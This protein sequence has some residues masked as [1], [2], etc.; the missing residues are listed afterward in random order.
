MINRQKKQESNILIQIWNQKIVL[1]VLIFLV[2]LAFFDKYNFTTQY[3]LRASV[4]KLESEKAKYLNLIVQAKKDKL[5]IEK[6]YEKFARE[7]Y[8]MSR[9]DEDVFIIQKT[10]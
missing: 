7:R 1:S 6:N 10:N 8:L 2:Y 4:R 5:D 9:P 3:K